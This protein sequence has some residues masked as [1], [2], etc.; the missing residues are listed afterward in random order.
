VFITVISVVI[1]IFWWGYTFIFDILSPF[2]RGVALEGILTGFWYMGG[3][4]FAYIIRKPGSAVLG[5]LIACVIEG[6]ISHWG[7]ASTL[8]YGV[9]EGIS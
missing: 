7:L 9:V 6:A 3:V 2:L 4:F 8:L 1:G 5:V